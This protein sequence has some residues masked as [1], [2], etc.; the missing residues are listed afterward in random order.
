MHDALTR[1]AKVEQ[2]EASFLR[3]LAG[4]ED[5]VGAGRHDGLVGA[6]GQGVDHVVHGDEGLARG[7]DR[8]V[9]RLQ[10]LQRHRARA[11]V[12]HDA[13]NEDKARPA[14]EVGD[15]VGVPYFLECGFSHVYLL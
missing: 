2:G 14:A 8:A 12:Q 7:H 4:G 11:L 3:R 1:I 9:R 15:L 5:E 6:A 13:V 10:A